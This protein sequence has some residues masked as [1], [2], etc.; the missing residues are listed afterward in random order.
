MSAS[1]FILMCY[2]FFAIMSYLL[3]NDPEQIYVFKELRFFPFLYLFVMLYIASIP[4]QKFDS[5]KVYSIQEPTM[6]KLNL[7]ASLFIVIACTNK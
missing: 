4:I 1:V 5:C 3:Y 2:S 7:F 6:W